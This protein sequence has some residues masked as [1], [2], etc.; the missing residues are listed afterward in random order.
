[1]ATIGAVPPSEGFR[2]HEDL[3]SVVKASLRAQV[4]G[5]CKVHPDFSDS[6]ATTVSG[7]R[8]HSV[9]GQRLFVLLLCPRNCAKHRKKKRKQLVLTNIRKKLALTNKTSEWAILKVDPSTVPIVSQ[10]YY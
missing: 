3:T 6:K 10:E 9:T 4:T 8:L 7:Q 1:M 2:S 5:R